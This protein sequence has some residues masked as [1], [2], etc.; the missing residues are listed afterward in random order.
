MFGN[1]DRVDYGIYFGNAKR[2]FVFF[3][4]HFVCRQSNAWYSVLYLFLLNRLVAQRA[5]VVC[6]HSRITL[7][8]NISNAHS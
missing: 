1:D 7:S 3:F 5:C 8:S 4:S 6:M 2:L